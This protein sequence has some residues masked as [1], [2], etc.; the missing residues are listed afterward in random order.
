ML[1]SRA[2]AVDLRED[3]VGV[4]LTLRARCRVIPGQV[5]QWPVH[6]T[7]RRGELR[8]DTTTEVVGEL[9]IAAGIASRFDRLVVPLQQSLRV[10][11][12]A[13]FFGVRGDGQVCER[14]TQPGFTHWG[15]FAELVAVHRADINLVRLPEHMS[16]D[17]AASLGCRFAT[18]Y[19]A[20]L[21]LAKADRTAGG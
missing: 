21:Q 7:G 13:R 6:L 4:R 9:Q 19:R 12:A 3:S 14:Q 8:P 20:I 11:E 5:Q 2:P 10:G 18:A 15:S 1:P 17:V 16:F